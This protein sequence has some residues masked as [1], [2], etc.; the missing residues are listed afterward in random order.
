MFMDGGRCVHCTA[1]RAWDS[2]TNMCNC[3][4]GTE[5]WGYEGC[6]PPCAAGQHRFHKRCDADCS[7]PLA[8]DAATGACRACD[9]SQNAFAYVVHGRQTCVACSF[10][11]VLDAHGACACR[12]GF[13][14]ANGHCVNP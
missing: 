14:E 11:E 12:P 6:L 10:D 5:D 9:A 3:P 13:R 2:G 7:A 8:N 4:A 1:D